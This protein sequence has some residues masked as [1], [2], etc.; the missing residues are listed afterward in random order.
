M[1]SMTNMPSSD[2][3]K[4]EPL[5]GLNYRQWAIKMMIHFESFELDY[6]LALDDVPE[7]SQTKSPA[8][9][10]T[11]KQL[12]VVDGTSDP[13]THDPNYIYAKYKSAKDIWDMLKKKYGADDVGRRKYMVGRLLNFKLADSKPVIEQVHEY[14][15]LV[16]D[17]EAEGIPVSNMLQTYALL[18]K[19]PES[20]SEFQNKIKHESKD[21]TWE[22]MVNHLNIEEAYRLRQRSVSQTENLNA[23]IVESSD[24]KGDRSKLSKSRGKKNWKKGVKVNNGNKFK[25]QGK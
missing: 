15:N 20:W 4:L 2:L 9:T 25:S 23:N 22:E 16:S 24:K 21:Y 6:I 7:A 10:Q 17:K 3:A 19:L 13:K 8:S 18:E 11:E 1:S 14:E 12:T 5:T